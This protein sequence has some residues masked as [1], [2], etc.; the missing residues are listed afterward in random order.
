MSG[1]AWTRLA[2]DP[3]WVQAERAHARRF[4]RVYHDW[5][6]VLRLYARAERV[7]HLPYDP[8]LDLA[9]LTH[10]AQIDM[11][12]DRRVRSAEWLKRQ[13]GEA[14]G[15][16][17]PTAC[18]LILNGPY[19]DLTDPRLPLLELSDLADPDTA[20][21]ALDAMIA[22]IRLLTR[23]ETGEVL[24][25]IRDELNRIRR[26]LASAKPLMSEGAQRDLAD[27]IISGCERLGRDALPG[28]SDAGGGA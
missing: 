25:G 10:S 19:K 11:G 5:D 24:R 20:E 22:Q 8:A 4:A 6:R 1:P 2:S 7:L 26:T 21:A 17:V 9:I 16:Q 23:L 14:H 27:R 18:R 15:D 13:A 12:G 3:L 28:R